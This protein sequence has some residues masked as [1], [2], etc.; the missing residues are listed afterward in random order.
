MS[1][2]KCPQCNLVN[3]AGAVSCKRCQYFFAEAATNADQPRIV[4]SQPNSIPPSQSQQT[5]TAPNQNQ[6]N[7]QPN[8]RQNSPQSKKLAIFS[9]ILGILSFPM[10]NMMIAALLSVVLAIGFGTVGAVIGFVIPLSFL[11]TGLITGITALVRAN[12]RP[13]EFGG[14][15]FAITGIV[16]SGFAI[17]VIPLVAAI[18]IPNLLA[19]RRSANEGSAISSFRTIADAQNKYMTTFGNGTYGDLSELGKAGLIDSVLASGTKS[20]YVFAIAKLPKGYEISAK[21]LTSNGAASTG[22]R[23]F[24]YSSED[25][26]MRA[27]KKNG[28]AA[29]KNDL[30]LES[31]GYSNSPPKIASQR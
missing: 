15:G 13:S 20:G 27:G 2:I 28:L 1:V 30:P 10:L 14:K 25:G 3:F 8:Y 12:K 17:I 4:Q 5:W 29:D 18:A 9:M 21:P 26:I 11:P 16:L 7:Y 23:S 6:A 19:A 22:T 31:T 24:Y